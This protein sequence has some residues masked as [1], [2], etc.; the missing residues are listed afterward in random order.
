MNPSPSDTLMDTFIHWLNSRGVILHPSISLHYY[1][2]SQNYGLRANQDIKSGSVLFSIPRSS[3]STPILSIHTSGFLK[4]LGEPDFQQIQHNWVPLLLT[5][6]WERARGRD[7]KVVGSE[8][9]KAYFDIMYAL[10]LQRK[11]EKIYTE[12]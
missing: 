8:S 5:M 12:Q 1:G 2:P 10:P 4:H 9:W 11:R 6:M 3:L 7:S